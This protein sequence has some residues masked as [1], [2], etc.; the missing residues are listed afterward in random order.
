MR[1]NV[2]AVVNVKSAVD[3]YYVELC[4]L[5]GLP[6]LGSNL[7]PTANYLMYNVCCQVL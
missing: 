3:W 1:F 5:T 7:L 6:T 2:I 4:S